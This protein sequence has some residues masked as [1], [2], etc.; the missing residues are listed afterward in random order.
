MASRDTVRLAAV[1]ATKNARQ[2]LSRPLLPPTGRLPLLAPFRRQMRSS[3]S[4]PCPDGRM[5]VRRAYGDRPVVTPPNTDTAAVR[6]GRRRRHGLGHA[7]E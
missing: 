7:W 4:R 2:R 1:T 5:P 3:A 6:L